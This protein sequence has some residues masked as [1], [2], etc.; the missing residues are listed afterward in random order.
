MI[1]DTADYE[2]IEGLP[3]VDE[4]T[5]NPSIVWAA[6]QQEKYFHLLEEA[7]NVRKG[8][9]VDWLVVCVGGGMC[10]FGASMHTH[11]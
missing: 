8:G 7:C 5:T 9:L 10:G 1:V 4:A 6:A 2:Q 3:L 11:K